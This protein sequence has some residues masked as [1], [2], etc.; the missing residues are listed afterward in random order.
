MQCFNQLSSS[1]RILKFLKFWKFQK[2]TQWNQQHGLFKS[3]WT[4]G[5]K[6]LKKNQLQNTIKN[7]TNEWTTKYLLCVMQIEL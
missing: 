6:N 3:N 7:K 4:F 5:T 2:L 1:H